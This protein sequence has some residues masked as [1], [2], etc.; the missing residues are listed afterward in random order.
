MEY[1]LPDNNDKRIF[2]YAGSP[3]K[4]DFLSEMIKGFAKVVEELCDKF[5]FHII[6][7]T[8]GAAI[9]VGGTSP[10][11]IRRLGDHLVFHGRV[12]REEA[13]EWVR[14]ADFT[15]LLRNSD[16][17]YTKAGFPTKV[18][19]SLASATPVITNITSDLG[20]YLNDG[21]NAVVSAGYTADDLAEAIRRAM[22]FTYDERLE[23]SRGA[24]ECA[25]NNFDYRGYVGLID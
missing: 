9:D 6:G 8:E 20:M 25:E 13:I 17:R 14:R 3:G 15:V 7:A 1:K 24:R 12:S 4:K 18:V 5:E 2:V 11:D 21:A 23:M 16:L 10:E 22:R 19:E